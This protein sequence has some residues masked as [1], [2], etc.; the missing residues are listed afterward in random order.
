MMSAITAT[1][2]TGG[3]LEQQF[4]ITH[5]QGGKLCPTFPFYDTFK[6]G[7]YCIHKNDL[8]MICKDLI[9]VWLNEYNL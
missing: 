4:W 8:G 6:M 5:F 9:G 3:A 7:K 2:P 1:I